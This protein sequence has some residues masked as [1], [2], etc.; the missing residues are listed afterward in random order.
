M[1]NEHEKLIGKHPSAPEFFGTWLACDDIAIPTNK[2]NKKHRKLIEVGDRDEAIQEIA[3]IFVQHHIDP[4]RILTLKKRKVEIL[5]KYGIK[6]FEEY[7]DSEKLFPKDP[8]TRR[9]NGAEILMAGYLQASSGLNLLVYRLRYNTNVE[10]SMKGD[11]CLLFNAGNLTEKVIVGEAKF[12]GKPD[13][14]SI[15]EMIDNL[16]GAKRLP[17]SLGFISNIMT[18]T[19]EEERAVEI[20]DLQFEL[21]KGK[22]PVVNVGL[23]MSSKSHTRS[24][25]AA[26]QVQY[27]L[28]STNPNLV[29]LSLGLDNPGQIIEK[30]FEIADATIR[31]I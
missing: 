9:G 17:I 3:N 13:K 8:I 20:S 15:L 26:L 28:D 16:Q 6:D 25:D 27:Y 11:D 14:E 30:A 4:K 31:S 10:Q 12:R 5:N 7:V 18:L 1:L 23:L 22:V 19:G 29:V 2:P 24:M 21:T